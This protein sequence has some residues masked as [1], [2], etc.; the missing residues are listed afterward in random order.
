MYMAE[1]EGQVEVC[2]SAG[3]K[4]K[5]VREEEEGKSWKSIMVLLKESGGSRQNDLSSLIS[6]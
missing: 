1:D 5:I 3:Q 4:D 2:V 6:L